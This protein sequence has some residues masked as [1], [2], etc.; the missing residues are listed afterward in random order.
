MKG[1]ADSG[2]V[3]YVTP[4]S[5]EIFKVKEGSAPTA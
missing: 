4:E 1:S 5:Q 3:L 2:F